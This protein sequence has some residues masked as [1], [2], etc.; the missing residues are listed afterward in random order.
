MILLVDDDDDVLDATA[1][2]LRVRAYAVQTAR[3][4]PSGRDILEGGDIEVLVTDYDLG[5][6]GD[7]GDLLDYAAA[8]FPRV[9][10]I[11]FSSSSVPP[12]VQAHALVDKP[13][14]DRLLLIIRA[15][16]DTPEAT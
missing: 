15:Y 7:G 9:V 16:C 6:D 4:V 14:L 1:E 2:F 8:R 11:V 13:D 10:R 3:S 12:Y 5:P